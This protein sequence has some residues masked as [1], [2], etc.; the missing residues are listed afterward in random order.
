MAANSS[1]VRV[2]FA[3]RNRDVHG[4]FVPSTSKAPTK[5]NA[6]HCIESRRPSKVAFLGRNTEQLII[7]DRGDA[8]DEPRR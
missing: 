7:R 1:R 8:R 3:L 4:V 6:T 2:P 5:I